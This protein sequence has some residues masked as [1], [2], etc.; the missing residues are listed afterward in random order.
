MEL[1]TR[2][3]AAEDDIGP[4]TRFLAEVSARA[5][6]PGIADLTFGNPHEMPLAGL[7][8][9]LRTQVEPRSEAWFAY[10]TNEEPAR[11]TVAAGLRDELGL[12]FEGADIAMTQGAFG[13][14][15]LALHLVADE[16]DEV[17]IPVP[18]WF[19]YAPM[20]RVSGLVPVPVALDAD[21]FDLDVDAI[22]D[23]VTNHTRIV[24]VNSPANPTG[25]VYPRDQLAR[26]AAALDERSAA[27]GRRIWILSDEPYRRIRFDGVPFTSPAAVYPWTLIDYSYGKVLLAPGQRLGYLAIGP[28]LP[29]DVR[30]TLRD[31]LVPTQLAIGWGF[32]DAL[33]QHAAP[34]L[35]DVTIDV[36]E[37]QR[38]RDRLHAALADAG[39]RVTRAE[40]TFYLWAEAPD[41]D[42]EAL[43]R[44]LAARGVLIMPGTLFDRPGHFRLSLTATNEAIEKALPALLD[45]APVRS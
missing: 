21:T 10:K 18:G 3:R 14:I 23:A 37:L 13:A 20:L 11:A 40:G 34:A 17:I 28:L 2:A 7:V 29:D 4:V 1:S 25:R 32:P 19:C 15:D 16:G 38:R 5:D 41:G 24:I 26:L 35:E 31:A 43:A 42:S 45:E 44:R 33:M 30:T 8:D 12:P 6:E 27:I 36:E 22:V 9:A 39:F